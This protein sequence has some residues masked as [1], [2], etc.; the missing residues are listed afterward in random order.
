MASIQEQGELAD[1]LRMAND[2]HYDLYKAL[3]KFYSLACYFDVLPQT[4]YQEVEAAISDV[5][6]SLSQI[7]TT[8]ALYLSQHTSD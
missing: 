7:Q 6:K 8:L 4:S 3:W 1:L 5:E 2:R